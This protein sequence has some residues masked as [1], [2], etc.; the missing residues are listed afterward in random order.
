MHCENVCTKLLSYQIRWNVTTAQIEWP[1]ASFIDSVV[2]VIVL[3]GWD[4]VCVCVSLQFSF[5]SIIKCPRNVPTL[6]TN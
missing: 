6:T 1:R 2:V 4:G 3:V 5:H